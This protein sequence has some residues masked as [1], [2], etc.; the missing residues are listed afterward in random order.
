VGHA[1]RPQ[2]VCRAALLIAQEGEQDV[3]GADVAVA[4][5]A[6]L[7]VGTEQGLVGALC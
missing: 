5:L 4:Q 6:R 7:V 3:L 1:G 2:R